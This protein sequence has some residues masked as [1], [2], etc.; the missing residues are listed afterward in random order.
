M[1]F[2]EFVF[3]ILY[4]IYGL[5][6]IVTAIIFY[7][8]AKSKR[9]KY[10]KL[11]KEYVLATN[12]GRNGHSGRLK[13]QVHSELRLATVEYFCWTVIAFVSVGGCILYILKMFG[14]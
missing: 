9:R 3:C 2:W 7:Y 6:L 10:K 1:T 13:S 11:K 5:A 8:Q 14:V 4:G 12:D